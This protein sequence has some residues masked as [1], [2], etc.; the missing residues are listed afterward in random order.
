M[1]LSKNQRDGFEDRLKRIKKGGVNTMGEVQIGPRDEVR[2]GK[3]ASRPSNT[4]RMKRKKKEVALGEGSN[5]VMVPVALFIGGL[6]MFVGGAAA[7]HF[8]GGGLMPIEI[9]VAAVEPVIPYAN[10]IFAGLLALIFS[11]TF[12]F[13]NKKRKFA[14]LLGL[15]AVFFF[16]GDLI[17]RFPGTYASM[18]SKEYVANGPE[19]SMPGLI[20]R[21]QELIEENAPQLAEMTDRISG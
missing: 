1:S 9:P 5:W 16:E 12:G 14:L 18:Y 7:Y 11:W 2:T 19:P 20:V 6:S 4:V 15:G 10:F 3:K 21:A 8:F 13:T 17:K